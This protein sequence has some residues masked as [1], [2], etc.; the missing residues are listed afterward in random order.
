MADILY[1]LASDPK[2]HTA[3]H[4]SY[5][6]CTCIS[7]RSSFVEYSSVLA[8]SSWY[9]KQ[10]MRPF[11]KPGMISYGDA[12]EMHPWFPSTTGIDHLRG[13]SFYIYIYMTILAH[14]AKPIVAHY[15]NYKFLH[16]ALLGL[17]RRSS[18]APKSSP[19]PA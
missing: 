17:L 18:K 13:H 1:R 10:Y 15:T 6:W 2:I 11:L 4:A 19:A 9:C 7:T 5:T 14:E 8:T 3:A 16:Q 12:D